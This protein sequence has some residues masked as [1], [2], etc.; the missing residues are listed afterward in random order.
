MMPRRV[1][2][3]RCH[4]GTDAVAAFIDAA[5][6]RRRNGFRRHAILLLLCDQPDNIG[7]AVHQA[8]QQRHRSCVD[9]LLRG[10]GTAS[11]RA[12]RTDDSV[13]DQN[14]PVRQQALLLSVKHIDM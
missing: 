10:G 8:G 9:G 13:R 11:T 7:V 3:D 14:I 2:T 5:Q 12:H 4:A 1:H 6:C